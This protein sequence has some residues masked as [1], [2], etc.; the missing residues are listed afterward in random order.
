MS[1]MGQKAGIEALNSGAKDFIVKPFQPDRIVE[2][3]QRWEDEW[4]CRF[5]AYI[6]RGEL[7]RKVL[8]IKINDVLKELANIGV[9]NALTLPFADVKRRK[10]E[11][12]VPVATLPPARC[13]DL[14]GGEELPVAGIYIESHG[15][16]NL[17]I[18]LFFLWKVL[19]IWFQFL[20]RDRR[21]FNEMGL[22]ALVESATF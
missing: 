13:A 15:D 3:L 21:E 12:D 17:T 8:S 16:I 22:S 19:P 2:A 20:C 18:L 11:M 1:A 4:F 6:K 7:R 5:R 14:L 10:V 9:G